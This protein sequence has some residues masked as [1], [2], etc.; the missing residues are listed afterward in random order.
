[1]VA[2]WRAEMSIEMG[3]LRRIIK[4]EKAGNAPLVDSESRGSEA[5]P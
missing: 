1:M 5:F 4:V 3:K 2:D